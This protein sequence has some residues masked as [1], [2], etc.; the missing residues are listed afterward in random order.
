MPPLWPRTTPSLAFDTLSSS[1]ISI[2]SSLQIITLNESSSGAMVMSVQ[3]KLFLVISPFPIAYA[4]QLLNIS[5][6]TAHFIHG[7]LER[8]SLLL[9]SPCLSL[10]SII[11]L[12]SVVHRRM[13]VS[14]LISLERI[15]SSAIIHWSSIVENWI[16]TEI[17]R[18]CSST[19]VVVT[20]TL[21]DQRS[22]FTSSYELHL[23]TSSCFNLDE[24]E[25]RVEIPWINSWTEE[26]LF[27][28]AMFL[29]TRLTR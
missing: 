28:N 15:K 16:S 19:R 1:L 6:S 12:S 4:W 7:W 26:Q 24:E 13:K 10:R 3:P 11:G 18:I 2:P 27:R 22:H 21:T 8:S 9:P 25:W 20:P 29:Q 23:H 14:T 5:S 17:V